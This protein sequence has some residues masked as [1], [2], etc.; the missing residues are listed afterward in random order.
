M[1]LSQGQAFFNS[2]PARA[3]LTLKQGGTLE[4]RDQV[5][6]NVGAQDMDT[7]RYEVSDLRD[8]EFWWEIDQLDVDAVFRPSIETPFFPST[9]D[10]FEM[11]SMAGYPTLPDKEQDKENSP[12]PTHPTNPVCERPTQPPVLMTSHPL[13]TRIENAPT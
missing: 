9:F 4:M 12:P 11:G 7:S 10:E 3:P 8:V 6:S 13:E 5:L 1:L 2:H